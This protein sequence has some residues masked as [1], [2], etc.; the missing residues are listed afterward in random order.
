MD[1]EAMEGYAKY[2]EEQRA[3]ASAPTARLKALADLG[4]TTAQA[5][6]VMAETRKLDAE[7][8]KLAGEME[9][10]KNSGGLDP[11]KKFNSELALNKEY[12]TRTKSYDESLRLAD[13]IKASAGA[14]TGA[15]D[16][17]LINTFMKMLDPGSVVRESEFAQAQDTAGLLGKLTATATRVANGQILTPDQ[18]KEFE[19]LAGKYM[20]A[21][22]EHEKRVRAGLD[23]MVQSY[24]LNADNVFGLKAED[25]TQAAGATTGGATTTPATFT[26][27]PSLSRLDNLKAYAKFRWPDEA[28]IID[29]YTDEASFKKKYNLTT[30][31]YDKLYSGA[32]ATTA[33]EPVRTGDF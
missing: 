18:R 15:G 19:T 24:G 29:A 14:G 27:S 8:T 10:A 17:A 33:Q 20:Q 23:F 22:T 9:A 28:Q 26:P 31:E 11:E 13:V 7:I 32:A 25:T 4:L 5:N 3:A 2:K 16:L 21:A 6:K 12:T 30:Q 1:K